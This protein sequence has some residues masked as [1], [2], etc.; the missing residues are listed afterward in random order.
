[1]V[2][3]G[4]GYLGVINGSIVD[5]GRKRFVKALWFL[6]N[7]RHQPYLNEPRRREA[8]VRVAS[9]SGE[10]RREEDR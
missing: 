2:F 1:M 9:P 6:S 3:D 7:H 4:S 5:V 8:R 10:E